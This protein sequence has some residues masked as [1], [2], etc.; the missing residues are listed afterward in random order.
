MSGTSGTTLVDVARW[1]AREQGQR[2]AFRFVSAAGDEQTLTYAELDLRARALAARLQAEAAPGS[3]A[4]ILHPPGLPYVVALLACFYT[5]IVAVPA[6]PPRRGRSMQ[7]ISAILADAQA[8]LALTTA[9]ALAAARPL[10]Q[11]HPQLAAVRWIASDE[12]DHDPNDYAEHTA[13]AADL[14]LLQ[15]TSGSTSTPKGVMV[16]HAN[17]VRNIASLCA[18]TGLSEEDCVVAWLPPYHDMGLVGAILAP[19]YVGAPSVLL[20]PSS[21]LA[22]PTLWL[23]A[24]SRYR[25]TVSGA[26]NFGYELC[27]RRVAHAQPAELDLRSWR[28]AFCGAERVDPRTQA[29][30]CEAFADSGFAPSAFVP[31]YGL[32]EATLGVS[33][34]EP[35]GVRVARFAA[36]ALAEG[37]VEAAQPGE[38]ALELVGCGPPLT[39]LDVLIV[40]PETRRSH[41]AGRVGEIWVR[42][43]SV[44]CGYWN[45]PLSVETFGARLE[46]ASRDP[47]QYLRTGDL[48]F[49]ADGQLFVT[50][51]LK[52]LLI[53]GGV[54]HY[55]EDI[56]G[57]ALDCH[58]DVGQCAAFSIDSDDG[59]RIVVICEVRAHADLE[60]FSIARAVRARVAERVELPV[61]DVVLVRSGSLPRT[62][63]GKLQRG[64]C[65][66]RYLAKEL[67]PIAELPL[68]TAAAAASGELTGVIQ[69]ILA[70]LLDVPSVA[71]D[72]NLFALGGHSLLATQLVSR[73]RDT[74]RV[75][76]PLRA[77]FD[78]PTPAALAERVA[79]LPLL[80]PEHALVPFD[81]ARELPLSFSQERM[82]LLHQL[83]PGGS[84]Y[85]VAGA[86][87]IEGALQA[88]LLERALNAIV[89]RHEVLR[90]NFPHKDGCPHVIVHEQRRV[91]VPVIDLQTEP[92]AEAAAL[93]RACALAS[94]PFE[95]ASDVLLR[96]ALYRIGRDRHVL[97]VC[98]HHLITDAW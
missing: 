21:F 57:S 81:R 37:R 80:S 79:S 3:R 35:G 67:S 13:P 32:A 76:L 9:Q 30:F 4:L 71:P 25:G 40:D 46:D 43:P 90:A 47:S 52:D 64:T 77:V 60:P 27:A 85:N 29:R 78:S 59:E 18:R 33:F 66:A 72:D 7:R 41:P 23:E 44:A 98:L 5:G 34:A 68:Q 22:R 53:I 65:R 86:A 56:E 28:V 62:S 94:A 36:R 6:Y 19:L 48:G 10:I 26:P 69:A 63:S 73:L 8:S 61:H 89:A 50:G 95:I 15:Y 49:F 92:D 2:V 91:D 70:D 75:E 16:S 93:A 96:V 83:E 51:R 74:L 14:A 12:V 31:C 24:I 38:P 42:G 88:E 17:F 11:K 87:R 45:D 84:A 1:R 54:N 55:P 20:P 39:D 82:W 97:A 58:P